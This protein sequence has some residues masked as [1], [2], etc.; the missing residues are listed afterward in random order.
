MAILKGKEKDDIKSGIV[1]YLLHCNE[2][3]DT[4]ILVNKINSYLPFE[5]RLK[6]P[7][8]FETSLNILVTTGAGNTIQGGA[9]IWTNYFLNDEDVFVEITSIEQNSDSNN[10]VY[11]L[12][13]ESKDLFF[14][15]G[16]VTHNAKGGEEP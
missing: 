9:D 5:E 7:S 16:I 12:D 1:N 13:V 15:N 2:T 11:K 14:A 3:V 4:N 6:D 8:M 10:F